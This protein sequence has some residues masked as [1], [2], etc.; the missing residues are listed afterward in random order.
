MQFMLNNLELFKIRAR[1]ADNDRQH[2]RMVLDK[3]RSMHRALLYS[4]QA[5]WIKKDTDPEAEW[6]RA[7]M[8]PDKVKFDY[9]EKIVSVD[10]EYGF[11]AGDTF[12]WGKGTGSHWIILKTEDTE[13]AYLR[14]NCRRCQYLTAIDPETHKE[15]SQWAAIRG[16]V[17]TKINVIQKAGIVADVPNLTLDIYMADTEA[18]R[19]TFERYKRFEFDGRY[20]KVQAPDYISTPGVYE[21]VA[22]E[23]YECHGDEMFIHVDEPEEPV[24]ADVNEILGDSSIKPVEEHYYYMKIAEEGTWSITLPASK[25]REVDDVLDYKVVGNRLKVTWTLMRSGSFIIHYGDYE[26]TVNVESLF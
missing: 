4:Y 6:V 21:I 13:L 23:D 2:N 16:P 14:G 22:E 10:W 26:K 18:N 25:N 15:F 5:A 24:P 7:L 3:K 1:A 9:D 19:R 12:E 8:N 20:W 17:E 11:H